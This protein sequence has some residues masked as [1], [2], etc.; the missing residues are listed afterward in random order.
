[1]KDLDTCQC[2]KSSA[3][4]TSTPTQEDLLCDTCRRPTY[5]TWGGGWCD[6][7]QPHLRRE[8][9]WCPIGPKGWSEPS[10]PF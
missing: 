4:C 7:P 10:K 1:M 9:A 2:D 6:Y 8:I 5:T 3:P